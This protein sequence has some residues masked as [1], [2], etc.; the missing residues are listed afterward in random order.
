MIRREYKNMLG[1]KHKGRKINYNEGMSEGNLWFRKLTQEIFMVKRRK[2]L[3]KCLYVAVHE[4][5]LW[6]TME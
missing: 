5:I 6:M 4:K 2:E 1:S 3:K